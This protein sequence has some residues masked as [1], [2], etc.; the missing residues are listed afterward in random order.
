METTLT[1]TKT[2]WAIDT[3]NSQIGFKVKYLMFTNVRGSFKEFDANIYTTGEGFTNAEI[4]FRII[5]QVIVL[6]RVKKMTAM[7]C[8]ANSP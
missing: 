4:D 7:N 5:L 8:M 6:L 1:D 3:I 2:K